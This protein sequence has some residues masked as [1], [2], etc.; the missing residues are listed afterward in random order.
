MSSM[1][2]SLKEVCKKIGVKA[3]RRIAGLRKLV[4]RKSKREA[5]LFA[6]GHTFKLLSMRG[7]H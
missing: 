2:E 7:Q 3:R 1:H 4:W 6:E 5:F